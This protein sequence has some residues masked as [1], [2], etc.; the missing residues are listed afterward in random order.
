MSGA[1]TVADCERAQTS[2]CVAAARLLGETWSEGGLTWARS[3]GHADLLFPIEIDPDALSA[4]LRRARRPGEIVGAWLSLDVDAAPLA[5][6]GFERGWSPWWMTAQIAD[7]GETD[8]PRVTLQEETSDYTG[9]HA[10]YARM[11]GLT[12]DRP[13]HT[14]YAAAYAEPG[15]R[16]AGRAWSHDAGGGVAGVFDMV[17]R[18]RF[19]R[20]GLGTALLKTV[21]AAARSAGAE[22]AVLN[23]TPDG[24]RL[25]D[26]CGFHQIGEGITWWLQPDRP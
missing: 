17:V 15:R 9:E 16:F 22:H 19:Q 1:I 25:Y 2:W 4:G 11:L 24:K 7:V 6:A 21:C 23:A 5:A 8:D 26:T 14:W 3:P 10:G 20:Q 12:R 18:P 13:K